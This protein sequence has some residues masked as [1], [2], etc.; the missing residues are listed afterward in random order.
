MKIGDAEIEETEQ[1]ANNQLCL[2]VLDQ[3]NTAE[4]EMESKH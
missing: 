1:L 2:F 3:H 4:Y